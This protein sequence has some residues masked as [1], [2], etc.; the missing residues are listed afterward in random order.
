MDAQPVVPDTTSDVGPAPSNSSGLQLLDLQPD[1][2]HNILHFLENPDLAHLCLASRRLASNTLQA[3]QHWAPKVECWLLADPAR[4]DLLQ[5][6]RMAAPVAHDNNMVNG[7]EPAPVGSDQQQ[8]PRAAAPVLHQQSAQQLPLQHN[9]K[10]PAGDGRLQQGVCKQL[11]AAYGLA[12][13]PQ[14]PKRWVCIAQTQQ[15]YPPA[16]AAVVHILQRPKQLARGLHHQHV[17]N[18]SGNRS[19]HATSA[20]GYA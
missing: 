5:R 18:D 14:V 9:Q 12:K 6:L 2:L 4:T 8:A 13:Q 19:V 7:P 15:C 20:F 17:A 1:V 11:T 3:C 10:V 16:A